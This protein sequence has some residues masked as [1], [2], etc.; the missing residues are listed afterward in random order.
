MPVRAQINSLK[1]LNTVSFAYKGTLEA[2]PQTFKGYVF[3]Y[4]NSIPFSYNDSTKDLVDVIVSKDT[5]VG[6]TPVKKLK[7]IFTD[8]TTVLEFGSYVT[9]FYLAPQNKIQNRLKNFNNKLYAGGIGVDA[10]LT[11]VPYDE[12]WQELKLD[13]DTFL[14]IS[15]TFPYH[16]SFSKIPLPEGEVYRKLF[17][18]TY[19]NNY[20]TIKTKTLDGMRYLSLDINNNI[21][22]FGLFFNEVDISPILF[23]PTFVSKPTFEV[24]YIPF[25]VEVQ[26]HNSFDQKYIRDVSLKQYLEADTHHL[27][28]CPLD[29]IV[30]NKT[31]YVNVAQLRTNFNESGTFKPKI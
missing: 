12:E 15:K 27:L 22:A 25:S 26:Y 18:V 21:G 23:K 17:K 5:F 19:N 24:G 30:L 10:L 29:D 8:T 11:V 14:Q 13:A 6:L 1:D 4:E 7:E 28:T 16:A 9:C 3:D 20:I 2:Q 31:P